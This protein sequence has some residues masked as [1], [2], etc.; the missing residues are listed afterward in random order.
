MSLGCKTE[1]LLKRF[2]KKHLRRFVPNTLKQVV[3]R[4]WESGNE[5]PRSST[6]EW[7]IEEGAADVT[8]TSGSGWSFKVPAES[9]V[10]LERYVQTSQ[11]RTE[12]EVLSIIS[13]SGGVMFDIGA[14][15]GLM[16]A[17]FCAAHVSN[18]AYSFEPSPILCR[19]LE[20][21]S[22]LNGFGDRMSIQNR[23]IGAETGR[24]QMLLDPVGGFV[25][26]HRFAQTM[27]SDPI[28][29]DFEVET[30][31]RASMRLKVVP[32][33]IKIDIEGYEFEAI[34]GSTRFLTEHRPRLLLELHLNYLEEKQCSAK[35][36]LQML[37]DCGYA[38]Y[39]YSGRVLSDRQIID[40]PLGNVQ[41]MLC[42]SDGHFL[43]P[44]KAV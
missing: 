3:R 22:N 30:I 23:G 21:I 39:S 20:D 31:E 8:C 43:P 16:S 36:L 9:L 12:L 19:R 42:A 17:I 33:V 5:L 18:R 4:H 25:Q 1:D 34:Q 37:R 29:I 44:K 26:S 7:R 41:L 40:S 11:G 10:D 15:A 6:R 38:I 32:D 28:E 27:W 14:H 13:E 35:E 2:L 24:A